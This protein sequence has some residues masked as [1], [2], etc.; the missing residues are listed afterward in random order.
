MSSE[1][2]IQ[3]YEHNHSGWV[4]TTRR[5]GKRFRRFFSDKPKGRRNALRAARAFK[6]KLVVQLP[7]PTK[8]KRTD[9]RNTTGVIGVA[10]VKERTRI[11]R[12]FARYVAQWPDRS[13]KNG[14]ATFSVGL[15]GE[16]EALRLAVAARRAGLRQA[17]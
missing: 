15:Y 7:R 4:V 14:R 3:R 1:H 5:R 2:L 13:G 6:D 11:G 9:I 10:R 12:W 8:I 16:Q 17:R